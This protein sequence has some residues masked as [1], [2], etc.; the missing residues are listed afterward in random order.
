M[1]APTLYQKSFRSSGL[2]F[3]SSIIW[4]MTPSP[5]SRTRRVTEVN[6]QKTIQAAMFGR[7]NYRVGWLASGNSRHHLSDRRRGET[8]YFPCLPL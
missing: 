8:R 6:R 1:N 3:A 4:N 2:D 5:S 7:A